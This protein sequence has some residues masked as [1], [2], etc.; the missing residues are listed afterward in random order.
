METRPFNNQSEK[1]THTNL[2]I[3]LGNSYKYY[4]ELEE[5]SK[6]FKREWNYSKLSGWMQK[7]FGNKKALYY[8][9]PFPDSFKISLTVRENERTEFLIDETLDEIYQLL[10]GAKKYSEGYA[11]QFIIT[12]R[13]SFL[14]CGN[15]ILKIIDKR[16]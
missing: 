11:L 12:D 10:E 15:L 9:I 13:S 14:P 6:T 1:P 3:A 5:L 8:L 4:L 2:K 16:S 7:V